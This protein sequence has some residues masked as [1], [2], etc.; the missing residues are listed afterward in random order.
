[1]G[2]RL[3]S[4][5]S[6]TLSSQNSNFTAAS[7]FHYSIST[8]SGNVTVTLPAISGLS[9]GDT[10]RIKF[11]AQGGTNTITVS[12]TGS[13]TIDKSN[14]NLAVDTLYSSI[15]FVAN[16]SQTDWELI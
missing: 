6:F 7:G 13:D 15:T 8:A 9:A 14:S 16:T 5:Q 3:M 1:M 4:F 11:A 12:S 2:D 10:L